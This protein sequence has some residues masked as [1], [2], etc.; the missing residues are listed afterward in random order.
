MFSGKVTFS[1]DHFRERVFFNDLPK[2][3]SCEVYLTG[4]FKIPT[5]FAILI[6][7]NISL[8]VTVFLA[9]KE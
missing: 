9:K 7:R 8:E 6:I 2:T 1:E 4:C 5:L 3:L